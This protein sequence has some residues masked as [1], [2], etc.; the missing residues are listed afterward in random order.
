MFWTLLQSDK[1]L[2]KTF[3]ATHSHLKECFSNL[4]DHSPLHILKV[5]LTC[6]T[7]FKSC[8]FDEPMSRIRCLKET[9]K[10]YS[11]GGGRF[12]G[13]VWEEIQLLEVNFCDQISIL[14][15]S[16]TNV[17]VNVWSG[18]IC[19]TH[20]FVANDG[21]FHKYRFC[22][23]FSYWCLYLQGTIYTDAAQRVE[24]QHYF[25]CTTSRSQH[26]TCRKCSINMFYNMA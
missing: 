13:Q 15:A 23:R 19:R 21:L 12:P 9:S 3:L 5:S 22:S 16:F 4:V 14:H 11:G 25:C 6:H 8:S 2:S 17:S 10:M 1:Q 7:Q 20:Q 24:N 26:K 18:Y